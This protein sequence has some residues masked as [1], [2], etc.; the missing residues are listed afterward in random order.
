MHKI[1]CIFVVAFRYFDINSH[2]IKSKK[3]P[4]LI[5]KEED[6]ASPKDLTCLP[7][8]KVTNSSRRSPIYDVEVKRDDFPKLNLN[9]DVSYIRCHKI[10]TINEKDL[11]NKVCDD[12]K[13]D[14]PDL[15]LKIKEKVE[16][17]YGDIL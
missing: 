12:F 16:C 7:I 10:Q 17:Y 1:G 6:G 9:S 13:D 11:I 5:I 14:Y 4:F 8:S 15:Y 2:S 3:R